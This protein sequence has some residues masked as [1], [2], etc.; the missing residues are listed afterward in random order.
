MTKYIHACE[1]HIEALRKM[2][3]V[4][5]QENVSENEIPTVHHKLFDKKSQEAN[6][7]KWERLPHNYQ[8]TKGTDDTRCWQ[9][10]FL[11]VLQIYR[12]SAEEQRKDRL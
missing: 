8:L 2:V 5:A 12:K 1:G 9:E 3:A 11:K 7:G 6:A 4:W 10:T